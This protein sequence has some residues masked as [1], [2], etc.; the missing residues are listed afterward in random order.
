MHRGFR[1]RNNRYFVPRKNGKRGVTSTK[2][3]VT[4]LRQLQTEGISKLGFRFAR[5]SSFFT[6]MHRRFR[7]RNNRYF[8]PKKNATWP[9]NIRVTRRFFPR[10]ASLEPRRFV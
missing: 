9:F 4:S 6:F 3:T 2:H 10:F 5:T 8:V 1:P 7:P